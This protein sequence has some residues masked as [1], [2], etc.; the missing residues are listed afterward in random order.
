MQL[1][2]TSLLSDQTLGCKLKSGKITK[3][4][5]VMNSETVLDNGISSE[6]FFIFL[7]LTTKAVHTKI[8]CSAV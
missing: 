2:G 7:S 8:Y 3:L 4:L 6:L 1:V 5:S